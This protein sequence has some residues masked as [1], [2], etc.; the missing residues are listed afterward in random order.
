MAT[1]ATMETIAFRK[2]LKAVHAK[3]PLYYNGT[4]NDSMLDWLFNSGGPQNLGGGAD[5]VYN[6]VNTEPLLS[7]L[8]TILIL[9]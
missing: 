6:W 8:T 9:D 4:E 3:H 2:G 7:P 1:E 5:S